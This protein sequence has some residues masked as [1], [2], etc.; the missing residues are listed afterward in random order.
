MVVTSQGSRWSEGDT[1]LLSSSL[2]SPSV[3][4]RVLGSQGRRCRDHGLSRWGSAPGWKRGTAGHP[5]PPGTY[6]SFTLG[7]SPSLS[8]PCVFS[9]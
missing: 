2:S 6:I 4:P 8:P 1:S 9:G 7:S 3:D 5:G